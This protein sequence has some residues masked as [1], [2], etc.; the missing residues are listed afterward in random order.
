MYVHTR[1]NCSFVGVGCC[2]SKS[3]KTKALRT[4]SVRS[5]VRADDHSMCAGMC[6]AF[7]QIDVLG[8]EKR[9]VRV[10]GRSCALCYISW[11]VSSVWFHLL[12]Q[13]PDMK[14]L[15]SAI[16]GKTSTVT[17]CNVWSDCNCVQMSS[18]ALRS[19]TRMYLLGWLRFNESL[20]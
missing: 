8:D 19:S 11:Q 20:R 1:S 14:A 16:G 15:A 4:L 10:V 5:S 13:R 6:K 3:S 7:R 9:L 17:L 12:W 18:E 2:T